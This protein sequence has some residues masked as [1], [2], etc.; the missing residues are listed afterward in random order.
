MWVCVLGG[1]KELSFLINLFFFSFS[2]FGLRCFVNITI[3]LYRLSGLYCF[4]SRANVIFAW[5]CVCFE[6]KGT[7]YLLISLKFFWTFR[8]NRFR[9]KIYRLIGLMLF[10]LRKTKIVG[11]VCIFWTWGGLDIFQCVVNFFWF[12]YVHFF[13][14]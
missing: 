10:H 3:I 1:W 11:C 7:Q 14:M 2:C 9:L 5:V 8:L 4:I 6:G 12:F 13:S